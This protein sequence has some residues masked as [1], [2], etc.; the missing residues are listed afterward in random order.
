MLL[1]LKSEEK[2]LFKFSIHWFD[3]I[4]NIFLGFILFLMFLPSFSGIKST[5]AYL[6]IIIFC[7]AP[8]LSKF[9]SNFNKKILLTNQRLYI[10]SGFLIKNVQE[11]PIQEIK[12]VE[13][14]QNLLQ[15]FLGVADVKILFPNT[16]PLMIQ[17]IIYPANLKEEIFKLLKINLN[18]V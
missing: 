12:N 8:M 1:N 9:V 4:P 15:K 10:E 17:R 3:M 18:K 13:I 2:I 6:F 16:Q 7:S 5:Y 11:F 14:T